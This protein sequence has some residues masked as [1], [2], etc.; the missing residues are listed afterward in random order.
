[1]IHDPVPPFSNLGRPKPFSSGDPE[2]EGLCLKA[3]A[4]KPED[5]TSTADAFARGLARWLEKKA[6]AAE[7]KP[8]LARSRFKQPFWI[9]AVAGLLL[10][11]LVAA[12]LLRSSSPSAR[13]DLAHAAKVLQSGDFA[14]AFELYD[15]MLRNDPSDSAVRA[16]REEAR[17]KLL[18]P[19]Q[20]QLEQALIDLERAR[21]EVEAASNRAKTRTIDEGQRQAAEE[22]VRILREQVQRYRSAGVK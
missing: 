1:M 11:G 16:G 21:V 7:G 5:R 3:L 20:L 4:K 12:L 22:R 19:A 14:L 18:V 6:S 8:K 13:K 2:I 9:A 15:Q 10:I 17:R